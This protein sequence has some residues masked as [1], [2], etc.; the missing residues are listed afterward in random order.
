MKTTAEKNVSRLIKNYAAEIGF[1]LCGIAQTRSLEEH[2]EILKRWALTGMNA[3]M[4]YLGQNITKRIDPRI[5]LPGAKSVIVTGL[6][7]YTGAKQG[8][9]G[10]PVISRYA[11]GL[12]YHSVLKSKLNKILAYIRTINPDVIGKAF[13]DSAPILEKAWGREAGLGWPGKHSVLINKEIGSFFF[14]GILVVNIDLDYDKPYEKD[15]CASCRLCIDACPTSAINDN[16]TINC[17]KCIAFQT[18][19]AKTQ[20]PDEVVVKLEGR[21]FGCDRCQEVCPW[22][23]KA[24]PHKTPEFELPVE[25]ERMTAENWKNLTRKDYKRLFKDSAIGRR[26]YCRFMDNIE[27]AL[28]IIE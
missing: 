14:I 13:V 19:E 9:N 16:R 26:S 15:H 12:N 10:V 1:D 27:A 20:I 22:N 21:I 3:D 28:Q 5:L 11:Y 17:P 4:T 23:D 2:R 6:N 25:V 18:L 24:K 7:Y 8:G